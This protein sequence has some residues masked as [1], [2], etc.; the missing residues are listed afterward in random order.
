MHVKDV[1]QSDYSTVRISSLFMGD[2]G[3]GDEITGTHKRR[4]W[5][6][7]R[8]GRLY[9]Q[10]FRDA[11]YSVLVFTVALEVASTNSVLSALKQCTLC[12]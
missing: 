9:S 10:V 1:I 4:V 8:V 11:Q 12:K 6:K 2:I 7:R 3:K 5:H